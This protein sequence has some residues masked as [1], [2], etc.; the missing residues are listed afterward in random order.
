MQ[1]KKKQKSKK[2]DNSRIIINHSKPHGKFKNKMSKTAI[3]KML[4]E[5]REEWVEYDCPVRGRVRQL[6]KVKRY[7]ALQDETPKQA[8]SND[9]DSKIDSIDPGLPESTV[10]PEDGQEE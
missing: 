2:S 6:V 4:V 9:L 1:K 7:R 5:E 10:E 8:R 3:D